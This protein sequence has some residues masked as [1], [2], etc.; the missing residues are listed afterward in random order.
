MLGQSL[1]ATAVSNF[2]LNLL[3]LAGDGLGLAL[4]GPGVGVGALSPHWQLTPVTKPPVAAKVHQAFD[5]DRNLAAK[6]PLDDKIAVDRLANLQDFRVGQFGDPPRGGNVHFF[7]KVLGLRWSNA[8]DI[9]KR[10]NNTL[11]GWNIDASDTSQD[12]VSIWDRTGREP[13]GGKLC[14]RPVE[15]GHCGT[16]GNRGS[17][18]KDPQKPYIPG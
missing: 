16:P 11:V 14:P 17:R 1:E 13:R 18:G 3:L 8:V 5:I 10:N 12:Q 15:T 9:L 2:L 4:A 6:V 7:A